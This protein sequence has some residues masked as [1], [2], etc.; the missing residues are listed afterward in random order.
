MGGSRDP[1]WPLS[2]TIDVLS[3][4]EIEIEQKIFIQIIYHYDIYII[5]VVQLINYVRINA[6]HAVFEY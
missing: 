1:P 3:R 5:N 4:S 2:H 6:K